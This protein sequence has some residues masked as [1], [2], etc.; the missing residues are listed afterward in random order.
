MEHNTTDSTPSD[1][2]PDGIFLEL[3]KDISDT[4]WIRSQSVYDRFLNLLKTRFFEWND[5][6]ISTLVELLAKY[7]SYGVED[8]QSAFVD[9]IFVIVP[10]DVIINLLRTNFGVLWEV[11]CEKYSNFFSES[12]IIEIHSD[13]VCNNN[14]KETQQMKVLEMLRNYSTRS[15][16][17]LAMDLICLRTKDKSKIKRNDILEHMLNNFFNKNA[18]FSYIHSLDADKYMTEYGG[19]LLSYKPDME[20]MILSGIKPE[21]GVLLGEILVII[22][23]HNAQKVFLSMLFS[24]KNHIKHKVNVLNIMKRHYSFRNQINYDAELSLWKMQSTFGMTRKLIQLLSETKSSKLKTSLVECLLK[25]AY[26]P[27]DLTTVLSFLENGVNHSSRRAALKILSISPSELSVKPLLDLYYSEKLNSDDDIS[28]VLS[29][30]SPFDESIIID[31]YWHLLFT[32]AEKLHSRIVD[33][34]ILFTPLTTLLD[35]LTDKIALSERNIA[36]CVEHYTKQKSLFESLITLYSSL[37]NPDSLSAFLTPLRRNGRIKNTDRESYIQPDLNTLQDLNNLYLEL[38][39]LT[40]DYD[41]LKTSSFCV[42]IIEKKVSLTNT[43]LLEKVSSGYQKLMDFE[44]S[45]AV[46]SL[47]DKNNFQPSSLSPLFDLIRAELR[48]SLEY[49]SHMRLLYDEWLCIDDEGIPNYMRVYNDWSNGSKQDTI[50]DSSVREM[51]QRAEDK[52]DNS[53][54]TAFEITQHD[55]SE[56][57]QDIKDEFERMDDEDPSFI[58][59]KRSR[60]RYAFSPPVSRNRRIGGIRLTVKV[61]IMD[62]LEEDISQLV[63]QKDAEYLTSELL[64]EL[65][66]DSFLSFRTE[67]IAL[68]LLRVHPEYWMGVENQIKIRQEKAEL[69]KKNLHLNTDSFVNPV[70]DI[71]STPDL[72]SILIR[73]CKDSDA[74]LLMGKLLI[75]HHCINHNLSLVSEFMASLQ[76]STGFHGYYMYLFPQLN[77]TNAIEIINGFRK[78]PKILNLFL[79]RLSKESLE[80][81]FWNEN[82]EV[83]KFIDEI[84]EVNETN[85]ENGTLQIGIRWKHRPR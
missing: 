22:S 48:E 45:S 70:A 26:G 85:I 11:G 51:L 73:Y 47:C 31:F 32:G 27:K 8:A 74:R 50:L 24:E 18:S 30:F 9:E 61:V 38:E 1:W 68:S 64:H 79:Q 75:N 77:S 46:Q 42:E 66:M 67:M 3:E 65:F 82:E 83:Q 84:R 2:F 29:I 7:C 28:L 16:L 36:N 25:V 81:T 60:H 71:H 4:N 62:Y 56:F 57:L 54:I 40:T 49:Y 10:E 5:R 58:D 78:N 13:F 19:L 20:D 53:S 39:R 35:K 80:N 23:P 76:A 52:Y 63:M 14:L 43:I 15:Y 72:L 34:L 69:I 6:Q 55:I 37:S 33:N 12:E 44:G 21:I 17:R 41:K 59:F